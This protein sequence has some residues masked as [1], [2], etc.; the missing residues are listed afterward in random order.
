MQTT[1]N[2]QLYENQHAFVWQSAEDLIELLLPQP[3]ERIL[4]LGCG[5]GQLTAQLASTGATV[6]GIDADATMIAKAQQNYP[7]LKFEQADA[8]NFQV[9][10]PVDAVFSNAMLHWVKEPERA[11]ECISCA[12]K[13][14][15]RLVVEFGGKGNIQAIA[16]ALTNT[17]ESLGQSYVSPWYFPSLGDYA[18]LLEKYGLEVVYGTLRDRPTPLQD[19]ETGLANWL[20]MFANSVFADLTLEMQHQVIQAIEAQARSTLY[21]NGTWIADYRRLRLVAVMKSL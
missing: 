2:S 4:D 10:A 9:E 14:G 3:G 18:I 5:T 16:Q 17:L 19:G 11:I 21:Q 15:G 20:R 12:L 1:W 7:H 8:R 13:P 6:W